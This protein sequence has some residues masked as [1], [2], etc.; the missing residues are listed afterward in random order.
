MKLLTLAA[1]ALLLVVFGFPS[2]AVAGPGCCGGC[3]GGAKVTG[4]SAEKLEALLASDKKPVVVDVLS[5]ESYHRAHIRGAINIPLRHLKSLHGKLPKDATIVT[6]C[7]GPSCTASVK[8]AG[9]LRALGFKDV[10]EYRGGI[11]EW[12]KSNRPVV[13]GEPV[14]FVSRDRLEKERKDRH[15]LVVIDVLPAAHYDKMHIAGAVNIPLADLKEKAKTL[16]KD[17][18]VV[19]YCANYVCGASSKAAV[20]LTKM[21]FRDVR[22][23]KGGLHEWKESKLPLAGSKTEAGAEASTGTSGRPGASSASPSKAPAGCGGCAKP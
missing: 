22:D 14:R 19:T 15:D 12:R 8:A 9:E 10:H 13:K 16:D 4:I 3:S 2:L 5:P 7:S 17:A 23:Y 11:S 1:A 6:Y 20:L 21:G 18:P